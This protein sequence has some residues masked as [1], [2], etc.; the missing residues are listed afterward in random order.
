[1]TE[2]IVKEPDPVLTHYERRN[3]VMLEVYDR[4]PVKTHKVC[5]SINQAKKLSVTLQKSGKKVVVDKE[6]CNFHKPIKRHKVITKHQS[7]KKTAR[8]GPRL[9]EEEGKALERHLLKSVK[10]R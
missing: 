3:N 5:D 1:M 9:T 6:A 7:V 8:V 4:G 10:V 2:E